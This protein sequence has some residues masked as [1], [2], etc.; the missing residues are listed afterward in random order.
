MMR[1]LF[2][3]IGALFALQAGPARG[4]AWTVPEG[5]THIIAGSSYSHATMAFDEHASVSVPVHFEK[6]LSS[7]WIEHGLRDGYTLFAVPQY[8]RADFTLP[9]G[10]P[11]KSDDFSLE[12]GVRAR[13]WD[14]PGVLSLQAS[15]KRAGALGMSVASSAH[16][17]TGQFELRLLYG[18]GFRFLRRN[19]FADLE[20]A[21]RRIAGAR[22][23]ETAIDF[24]VGLDAVPR[25]QLLFQSFN[26]IAAGD[27][28]PPYIY[29]RT[30]KLQI[31]T[32]SRLSKRWSLQSA[33]FYSPTGQNALVEQGFSL[34]LWTTF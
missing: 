2:C 18:S 17:S 29:Y 33:F 21:Q 28:R 27:A 1:R 15:Y 13:L 34:S 8:A 12:A 5:R 19:G 9:T 26:I 10:V 23:D 24:T 11:Q 7:I 25:T 4:G 20:I 14:A 16:D 30:H 22:P 3:L 6:L 31:S 32:V